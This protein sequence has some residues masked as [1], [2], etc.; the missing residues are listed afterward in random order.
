MWAF[1]RATSFCSPS[2]AISVATNLDSTS[3]T[4]CWWSVV[5][6]ELSGS[7]GDPSSPDA[8]ISRRLLSNRD[9]PSSL[10]SLITLA[11]AL[12]ELI[13]VLVDLFTSLSDFQRGTCDFARLFLSRF[14][15]DFLIARMTFFDLCPVRFGSTGAGLIGRCSADCGSL[16]GAGFN[17]PHGSDWVQGPGSALTGDRKLANYKMGIAN[18]VCRGVNE[19][20]K[21]GFIAARLIP[22]TIF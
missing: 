12:L 16:V 8:N 18:E 11:V 4:R 7:S 17:W 10:S 2:N 19:I 20:S 3:M 9:N 6:S 22:R 5:A 1:S 14:R 21:F 15:W 13:G